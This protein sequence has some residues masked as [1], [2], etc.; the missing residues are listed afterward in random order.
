MLSFFLPQL[1]LLSEQQDTNWQVVGC[2]GLSKVCAMIV[3]LEEPNVTIDGKG[4]FILK[5]IV[6]VLVIPWGCPVQTPL[7]SNP[8]L[9]LKKLKPRERSG[10]PEVTGKRLEKPRLAAGRTAPDGGWGTTHH[11]GLFPR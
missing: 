4:L 2:R 9:Q 8:F 7:S 10:M 11:H 1:L 5:R 3:M 6:E